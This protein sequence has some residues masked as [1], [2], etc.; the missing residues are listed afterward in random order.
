MKITPEM[1][2]VAWRAF[3][4]DRQRMGPG[5]GFQEAIAAV[6]PLILEEA[7]KVADFG[8]IR[9]QSNHDIA[10]AIRALSPT[11]HTSPEE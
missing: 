8:G 5:P 7:A 11:S 6:A 10:A 9:E 2:A 4:G 3:K 1:L